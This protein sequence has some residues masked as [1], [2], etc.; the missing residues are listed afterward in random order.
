M[1]I[2]DSFLHPN[3]RPYGWV[4]IKHYKDPTPWSSLKAARGGYSH[5]LQVF[6]KRGVRK[7]KEHVEIFLPSSPKARKLDILI[8]STNQHMCWMVT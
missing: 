4:I 2:R 5:T 8:S 1:C 6:R 3:L 7:V